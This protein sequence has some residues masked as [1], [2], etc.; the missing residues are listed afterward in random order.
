MTPLFLK[1]TLPVVELI[2][3]L[4]LARR[5]TWK[6]Y[7]AFIAYLASEAIW[8]GLAFD[9]ISFP[10]T[11]R[12]VQ[13]VVRTLAVLEVLP[14]QIPRKFV[15]WAWALWAAVSLCAAAPASS[16]LQRVYLFRQYWHIGLCC[17]LA[18]VIAWRL[19]IPAR[20]RPVLESARGRACRLGMSAYIGVR[21]IS[22]MFFA[23]G[24]AFKLFRYSSRTLRIVDLLTY[25]ALLVTV[26]VTVGA[27]LAAGKERKAAARTGDAWLRKVA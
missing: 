20:W 3:A 22:G 13:L 9:G 7:P 4:V 26:L 12:L 19:R 8:Q 10:F 15:Y 1:I 21:T 18:Y 5:I 25:S 2:G 27:M 24:L 11:T 17:T 23:G 16:W 6:K 14:V